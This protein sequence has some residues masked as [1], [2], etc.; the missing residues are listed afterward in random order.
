[1][2]KNS[3]FFMFLI[4]FLFF[5]NR[6]SSQNNINTDS[7]KTGF[8]QCEFLASFIEKSGYTYKRQNLIYNEE[9]TFP[10]NIEINFN[11]EDKNQKSFSKKQYSSMPKTIAFIIKTE[12]ALINLNFVEQLIEH[13]EKETDNENVKLVFTYGDEPYKELPIFARGSQSFAQSIFEEDSI[14]AICVQFS[15]NK[16]S[17]IPGSGKNCSPSWLVKLI[18]LSFF[19]NNIP[20]NIKGTVSSSLY[21]IN[22]LKSDIRTADF[23]RQGIPAAG[24]ELFLPSQNENFLNELDFFAYIVKNF[25]SFASEQWDQ[26]CNPIKIGNFTYILSEK[27]SVVLLIFVAFISLFILCEFSFITKNP[28]KQEIVKDI[29]KIWYIIPLAILITVFSLFLGQG[30]VWGLSKFISFDIYTKIAIKLVIG[31]AITSFAYLPFFKQKTSHYQNSYSYITTLSTVINIFLF[32]CVDISLFY[33]FTIEYL[34]VYIFRPFKKTWL[35]SL[36]F[37]IMGIPFAPYIYEIIKYGNLQVIEQIAYSSFAINIFTAAVFVPFEIQWFRI[38]SGLNDFWKKTSISARKFLIQ[39]VIAVASA[40]LIFLAIMITV[41][42]SIPQ[43]YK[44]KRTE[45]QVPLEE[46]YSETISLTYSDKE[47]FS[48]TERTL[49]INLTGNVQAIV[50]TVKGSSQNSIIYSDSPFASNKNSFSDTFIIPQRPPK[51]MH[52]N[53][54]CEPS[55]DSTILATAYYIKKAANEPEKILYKTQELSIKKKAGQE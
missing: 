52:F 53:Y 39:N 11:K 36:E 12:D 28:I 7:F 2:K 46:N 4:I 54:I 24:I 37:I 17:L 35:L 19:K 40:I 3:F 27:L 45:E 42:N 25:N 13:L 44:N 29:Q 14:C 5:C 20:Y 26:H 23:L 30:I 48:E 50:V 32:T 10:Y 34:I 15:N 41:T 49:K 55:D 51:S 22:I 8:E 16:T 9:E 6:I 31:F 47:Y 21:R 43:K 1:M 33:L 18:S 38:L